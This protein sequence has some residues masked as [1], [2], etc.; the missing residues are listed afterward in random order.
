MP[1][2]PSAGGGIVTMYTGHQQCIQP[3]LSSHATTL[4]A[5]A[6]TAWLTANRAFFYPFWLAH[7]I[8]VLKMF[9]FNGATAAGN[10][11]V[12]IYT[13]DGRKLVS[14]GSTAQAGTSAL[15][16]FDITDTLLTPGRYYL[17]IAKD[18][19]TGTVFLFNSP[20]T[21]FVQGAGVLM[22]E[23]AFA[24]PATATFATATLIQIPVFGFTTRAL[25]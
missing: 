20:G 14:S 15:Q 22:Q 7:A 12:G 23:T 5:A 11:D 6:S 19:T 3:L 8:T 17:A 18:D 1:T 9:V 16:E 4:N 10:I 21:R 2:F 13:E 25:L 24:L